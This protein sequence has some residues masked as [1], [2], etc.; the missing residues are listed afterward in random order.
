MTSEEPRLEEQAISQVVQA[1]LS[2][3]LDDAED[4]SVNVRTDLG[5][6]AQ[7]KVD[8]VSVSGKGI[9]LQNIR[10]QALDVQTDQVALNPLSALLGNLKLNHSV[11]ATARV[12]LTEADVNQAINAPAIVTKIPPLALNVEDE[13]VTVKLQHP[14]AIKLPDVDKVLLDGK[15]SLETTTS[16]RTIEFSVVIVPRT[17]EHPVLMEA[18]QCQPGEGLSIEFLIALMKRFKELLDQPYYDVEGTAFRVETLAV[19]AGQ[20]VA[21]VATHITEIPSL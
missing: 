5:K 6:A 14:L 7:G 12:L 20:L 8:S 10:I 3:Q 11:D 16:T 9:S 21:E 4:L 15:A 1:G 13:I 17:D 2:S 18:F 19:Q